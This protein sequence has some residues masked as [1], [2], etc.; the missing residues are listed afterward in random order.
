MPAASSR[1]CAALRLAC[2][3]LHLG[4]FID[5]Y[6][7]LSFRMTCCIRHLNPGALT[8]NGLRWSAHHGVVGLIRQ[9]GELRAPSCTPDMGTVLDIHGSQIPAYTP[10]LPDS[11]R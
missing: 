7:V 9:S 10:Y 11:R 6:R 4:D 5:R 3:T 8:P 2:T 1:I